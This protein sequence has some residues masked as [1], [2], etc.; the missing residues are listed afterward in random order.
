MGINY[1][2]IIT[3]LGITATIAVVIIATQNNTSI[4]VESA[5]EKP[6]PANCSDGQPK[7]SGIANSPSPILKKL[8]E[9]E[10]V[11]NGSVTDRIMTF[12]PMPTTLDEAHSQAISVAAG[13]K[14]FK[15]HSISPIVVFEPSLT[16]ANILKRIRGGEF[17]ATL[18]EYYATLKREG[19]T[20]E[21]M[22]TWVLFPEANTPSWTTTNPED[23][24]ANTAKVAQLQKSTFPASKVSILLNS[25]TYPDNDLHWSKGEQKSL[26]PYLK[27]IP[28]NLID[29]IGYQGFPYMPPA[30]SKDKAQLDPAHFLNHKIVAEASDITGIKNIWLNTGTFKTMHAD[31]PNEKISLSPEERGNI[32]NGVIK[33]VQT[34]RSKEL[35]VTVNLFA[36]DKTA[37]NEAVDWSYWKPGQAATS[38]DTPI[39]DTFVRRLRANDTPLSLY[40]SLH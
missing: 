22:G 1:A 25:T 26:S 31:N 40:D 6:L 11:C 29:S 5:I 39:F 17:D 3:S 24:I 2:A 14:E 19:V 23:F 9:Y 32:L 33:Q 38:T 18:A 34:L 8:A 27:N 15:K 16:E 10:A 36:E 4:K 20:D 12:T 7:R 13:L 30:G 21:V 28:K 35:L 37:M